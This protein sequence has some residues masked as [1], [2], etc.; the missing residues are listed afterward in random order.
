MAGK[1]LEYLPQL[2]KQVP[3]SKVDE[4]LV[5]LKGWGQVDSLCQSNFTAEE[6]LSDWNQWKKTIQTLARSK[7][8]NK[9]RA[10][11]VLLTKPV[12]D[13]EDEWLARLALETIEHL[14]SEKDILIT[15]AVS[16]L[17]RDLIKNH[18]RLVKEYLEKNK[19]TLPRIAVRETRNKLLTGR[20]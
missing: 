18:R 12:R 16:W 7:N 14:K 8:P 11:L 3:P 2:R 5:N 20:K 19:N 13:S 15:K 4:W 1:L 17:L 6:L 9:K 10:S